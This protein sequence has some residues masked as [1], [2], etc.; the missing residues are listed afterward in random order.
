MKK[1]ALLSSS[2]AH[3]PGT[4]KTKAGGGENSVPHRHANSHFDSASL[5]LFNG[6]GGDVRGHLGPDPPVDVVTWAAVLGL[7]AAEEVTLPR[8][9]HPPLS[10]PPQRRRR[11]RRRPCGLCRGRR[12]RQRPW[13]TSR[14][15]RRGPN[16][17]KTDCCSSR[18]SKREK[19]PRSGK[20][21][22]PTLHRK[23]VSAP[24]KAVWRMRESGETRRAVERRAT[25]IRPLVR[26]RRMS[27]CSN[28]W[29]KRR[30]PPHHRQH[31]VYVRLVDKKTQ[32]RSHLHNKGRN[33]SEY[34]DL[35]IF[36]ID[37]LS[38]PP[39]PSLPSLPS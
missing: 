11:R 14:L 33:Q 3:S 10:H 24:R 36:R 31:A 8:L 32:P 30:P 28:K 27:T 9:G 20:A 22:L 4:K 21:L 6:G 39:P 16:P 34:S 15:F 13:S 12:R 5:A 35:L 17:V 29:M 1:C 37:L 19:A 18:S 26:K 7:A 38:D 2:H 23:R 25:H